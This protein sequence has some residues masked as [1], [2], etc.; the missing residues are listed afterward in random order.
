MKPVH[1]VATIRVAEAELMA[2]LPDGALMQRAATGLAAITARLIQDTFG[3][4]PGVRLA[5]VAGSGNNG[6][7]ALFAA[8]QLA[9]RGVQV[10]VVPTSGTLHPEGLRAAG[11][12]VRSPR[13]ADVVLDA[14]VGIGGTGPLRPG[15][16]A[17]RDAVDAE[18]TIAVDLP[19]GLEPDTGDVPGAVWR[20]DHTVTFGTLKPGVVLRPDVCG[21]V[22]LVDIGLTLPTAS[23]HAVEREDA[24]AFLARPGFD[25][26]KYTRG[27]VSVQAGSQMYPGA[28]HLCVMGARHSGAGMV[29][30][31]V[32]GYPDVVAAEGRTD[33]YVVGPGLADEQRLAAAI[34]QALGSGRPVVLDAEALSHVEAG[35]VVITPHTGE[36]ARLGFEV[37]TD[38]IAAVREAAAQL[39]VVVLLKG[40][41]TVV[42]EPG[43]QVFINTHSSPNL[44][45]AGSGDV[46]SGLLGGMLAGL[47]D[48]DLPTM[49][50]LAACAAMVHG[51]AGQRAA[52][53][54]TSVDIAEEVRAAV[55]WAS[56]DTMNP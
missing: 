8:A 15:A 49:A 1:D 47:R 2:Q 19:S 46:L 21:Q 53:P 16:A 56:A 34:S 17:I 39:G 54:A 35:T 24:A 45:A 14:V 28:G 26:N 23:V 6:G 13:R 30:S 50:R 4:L 7:D 41:V 38:R 10:D 20:A 52:Y 32:G 44:A 27:V 25:D 9:R 43:G 36:F 18:L 55:A 37:G 22:H 3:R 12:R 11:G 29:R 51:E 40:A 33:A 31:P 5:V 48:P 42:A